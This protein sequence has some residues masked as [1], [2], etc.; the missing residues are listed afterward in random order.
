MQWSTLFDLPRRIDSVPR[1]A[2]QQDGWAHGRGAK[3]HS[4]AHVA[5]PQASLQN[6]SWHQRT[7][8]WVLELRG[9]CSFT[10]TSALIIRNWETWLQLQAVLSREAI[11]SNAAG[12]HGN[13]DATARER[14]NA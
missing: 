7:I 9:N 2:L 14:C 13:A 10:L 3:G 11:L 4:R 8:V 5:S 6:R 1:A 12:A